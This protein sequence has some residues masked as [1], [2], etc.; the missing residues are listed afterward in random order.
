MTIPLRHFLAANAVLVVAVVAAVAG[1]A[2]RLPGM[3]AAVGAHLALAG[4]VCLTIAGALTQF[5]PVWSGVSLYSRRLAWLQLPLLVAGLG[6][7]VAGLLTVD[8]SLVAVGG[9]VLLV[10]F[11]TMLYNVGRTLWRGRP[12]DYTERHFALALGYFL[13][14]TTFGITLAGTLA[15][16]VEL[17]FGIDRASLRAAHATLAVFGA[18]ATTIFGALSQLS[19]MFTQTET[20][21]L[22]E[23]LQ[24]FEEIGYPVGVLTLAAGRLFGS[25]PLARVGGLLV[26]LGL[27]AVVSVLWRRLLATR[28]PFSPT[29]RRYA[30]VVPAGL[31]WAVPTIRVWWT[32][33]LDPTATF[34]APAATPLLIGGVVGF[35]VVGTLYH[36]IPFVVWVHEYSDRLG[37]E[38]VPSL[39][40]LYDDRLARVSFVGFLGALVAVTVA[41]VG[42]VASLDA[43][44]V[45][46]LLRLLAVGLSVL[47]TLTFV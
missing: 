46:R 31:L 6:T 21:R 42:G 10:G 13:L 25:P 23:R 15:V 35:V 44:V 3:T 43:A 2:G 30:V 20:T 27:V 26:I 45:E 4:W 38:D 19:S 41:G 37:L 12:W 32:S 33:P 11:W 39:D 28:V 40:D 9:S 22:D 16:P 17:P 34:G 1:V 47:G 36:V 5:V 14:V 18:V 8:P 7:L 24:R 29:L